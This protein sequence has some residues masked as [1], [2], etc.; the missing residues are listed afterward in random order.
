M[1]RRLP[2]IRRRPR[3]SQEGVGRLC[4]R[5]VRQEPGQGGRRD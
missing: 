5:E 4:D 3:L 1:K 2:A